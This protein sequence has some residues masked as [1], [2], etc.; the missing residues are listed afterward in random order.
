MAKVE[1]PV[2]SNEFNNFLKPIV[3][4]PTYT[5]GKE[6]RTPIRIEQNIPPENEYFCIGFD[7][8]DNKDEKNKHYRLIIPGGKG[9]EDSIFFSKPPFDSIQI[10]RGSTMPTSGVFSV[11]PNESIKN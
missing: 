8:A 3:R 2:D 4:Y 7:S 5:E 11:A 9:L 1:E 10:T 6:G